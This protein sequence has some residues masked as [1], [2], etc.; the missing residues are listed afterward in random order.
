MFHVSGLHLQSRDRHIQIANLT[1]PP[2]PTTLCPQPQA[3]VRRA[4]VDFPHQ[5]KAPVSA[6]KGAFSL[7]Y[8]TQIVAQP[9]RETKGT[10]PRGSRLPAL[11]PPARSPRPATFSCKSAFRFAVSMLRDGDRPSMPLLTVMHT[12]SVPSILDLHLSRCRAILQMR[13]RCSRP[14]ARPLCK[15][16]W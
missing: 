14:R 9:P 12:W 7:M 4:A 15:E 8:T 1:N 13:W 16:R 11:H 6:K 10:H 3:V 2:T 5:R